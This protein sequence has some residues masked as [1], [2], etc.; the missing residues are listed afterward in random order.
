MSQ[1]LY[2]QKLERKNSLIPNRHNIETFNLTK[3]EFAQMSRR[4][5]KP[6]HH[7]IDANTIASH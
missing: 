6:S 2:N 4:L 1:K 3:T 5:L 7:T